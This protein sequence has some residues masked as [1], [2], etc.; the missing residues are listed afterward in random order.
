MKRNSFAFRNRQTF[1]LAIKGSL[2]FVIAYNINV[3]FAQEQGFGI[4]SGAVQ[5]ADYGGAVLNAKVTFGES[6][7]CKDER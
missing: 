4:L 2:M 3:L 7:V 6:D 1:G 5:D